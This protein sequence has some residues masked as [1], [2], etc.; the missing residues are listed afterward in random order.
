MAFVV[1]KLHD[2]RAVAARQIRSYARE[3]ENVSSRDR[4]LP[5]FLTRCNN[6][7][8][9]FLRAF[10]RV[11]KKTFR[12]L[13]EARQQRDAPPNVAIVHVRLEHVRFAEQVPLARVV[14]EVRAVRY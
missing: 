14:G 1:L 8:R 12:V 4:T 9:L 2:A 7:L 10:K 13:E 5:A 11:G 6:P 3:R